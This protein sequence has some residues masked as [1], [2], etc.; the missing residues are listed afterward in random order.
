MLWRISVT[1][2]LK[3]F[4]ILEA[5]VTTTKQSRS[6]IVYYPLVGFSW[7]QGFQRYFY[8]FGGLNSSWVYSLSAPLSPQR[9]SKFPTLPLPIPRFSQPLNGFFVTPYVTCRFIPPCWHS[10]GSA[11]KV[12][13]LN[14]IRLSSSPFAPS[15]LPAFYGFLPTSTCDPTHYRRGFPFRRLGFGGPLA[16][17]IKAGFRYR[18]GPI[19]KL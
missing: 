6:A 12:Y 14:D 16:L 2:S 13:L 10:K 7:L 11:F 3:C 4:N 5:L 19:L 18:L 8:Q 15:S 1:S 9:A 17:F